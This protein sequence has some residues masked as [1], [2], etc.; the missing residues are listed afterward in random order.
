MADKISKLATGSRKKARLPAMTA[1]GTE[2]ASEKHI[3]PDMS[4]KVDAGAH[5]VKVVYGSKSQ[6]H[7]PTVY[8]KKRNILSHV[9]AA[10]IGQE[11]EPDS[12][13]V[14]KFI[15]DGVSGDAIMRL[16]ELIS[17]SK[18][19]IYNLLNLKARTAQ[20][21]VS[22]TLDTDKSGHLV[23]I[24]KLLERCV[25]V[26]DDLEKAQRW[27]KSPNYALG[28]QI[29]LELLDTTEG[30]ELVRDTLTSIEYGAF[31]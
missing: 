9:I 8:V 27:L 14:I 7:G 1:E 24:A 4:L 22:K 3:T 6:K 13:Q 11:H 26:F 18:S 29:P 10:S 25:E 16:A 21:Q 12:M 20:R 28:H 17:I 19:D 30:I 5:R 23:Q 2:T 31:V 15:R